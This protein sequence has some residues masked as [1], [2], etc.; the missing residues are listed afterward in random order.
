M[1]EMFKPGIGEGD[2]FSPSD[3]VFHRIMSVCPYVASTTIFI[4]P[5][6][7]LF[8]AVEVNVY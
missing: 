1:L 2:Y 7:P 8:P 5:Y 6:L 3:Y 4:I